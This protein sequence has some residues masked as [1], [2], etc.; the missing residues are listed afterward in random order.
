[1]NLYTKQKETYRHRKKMYVYKRERKKRKD[2][3]GV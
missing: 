1:M 2:K 3:L